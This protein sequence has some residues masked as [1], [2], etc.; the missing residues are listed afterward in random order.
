[1]AKEAKK[2][3]RKTFS[4][5]LDTPMSQVAR[6]KPAPHG[7]YLAMV[8]GLP[9]YDKST[10]KGTPF[11]EYTL[12]LLEALDDVDEEA[13]N[14]WLAKADGTVSALRDKTMRVTYYHTPDALWRLEKFLKDCGLEAEDD[15]ES[16]GDVEQKTPGRQLV[17]HVKHTPSD[18]GET[19]FANVDKTGPAD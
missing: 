11:S 9:R 12:Q 7:S 2:E 10:K 15:E 5:I 17:I 6:P 3:E 14:E 4:S 16:I 13:L 1:M 8:R 19:M 18:D